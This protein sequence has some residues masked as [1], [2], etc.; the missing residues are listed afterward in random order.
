VIALATLT[1][2]I[3]LIIGF[4][5]GVLV[6]LAIADRRQ[7]ELADW[8]RRWKR[9]AGALGAIAAVHGAQADMIDAL[10]RDEG[11]G[12]GEIPQAIRRQP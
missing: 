3:G 10:L 9:A 4:V 6:T 8:A 5:A 1:A 11:D 2:L 12:P 7:R